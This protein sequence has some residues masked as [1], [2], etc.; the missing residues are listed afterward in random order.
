MIFRD[1]ALAGKRILV[2]G[3]SSGIGRGAAAMMAA[4]GARLIL[5]ARDAE[6]LQESLGSLSGTGH[7]A[8][9]ADIA[10]V[11]GAHDLLVRVAGEGGPLD[12]VFHAAGLAAVRM[13]KLLN[14]K[15][16]TAMMGAALNGALGIAKACAKQSVMRDGGSILIMS[17]VSAQRGTAGM[18]GYS[19]AKA[20]VG[21]L[22]RSLAAELAPRGTRVNELISGAVETPMHANVVKDLDQASLEAHRDCHMLGLGRIDD[23]APIAT[24]LMS[25]AARWITGASIAVDGG[26]TA[27]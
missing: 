10:S 23:I 1:D 7:A 20:A 13:A 2:S 9:P 3:A 18:V 27:Q 26:Y 22:T 8:W 4:C 14:E 24:F 17:S 16:L 19:A 25:D 21:G 15:H 11:D 12:G 6:R 5:V